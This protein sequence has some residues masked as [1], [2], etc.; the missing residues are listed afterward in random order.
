[1]TRILLLHNTLD[2][3]MTI[4]KEIRDPIA[5]LIYPHTDHLIDVTLV[6][7]I[8]HAHIQ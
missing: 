8:D 5:L 4:T 1:M 2:Y 3:D 7:D 6:T